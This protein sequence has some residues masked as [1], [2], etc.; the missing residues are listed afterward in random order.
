M[1]VKR[2]MM[3]P[4]NDIESSL[5][6]QL[7]ACQFLDKFRSESADLFGEVLMVILMGDFY[8]FPPVKGL[9]LWRPKNE[10]IA[11]Q[12]IWHRFTNVILSDEQMWQVED[13]PC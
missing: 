4:W 9:P 1:F 13:L 3:M 11:G 7:L 10:D 12:Q 6:L 2:Y 5:P 8:Q